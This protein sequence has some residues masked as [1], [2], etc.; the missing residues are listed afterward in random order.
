MHR[1]LALA[2]LFPVVALAGQATVLGAQAERMG[3]HWRFAV[4]V[5]HADTGWDHY[6]DAW[7]VQAPDGTRLAIRELMHPHV[8]EQPFTRTLS[9]VHVPAHVT[10]VLIRAH[11]TVEGW[12]EPFELE[13]PR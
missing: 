3:A 2:L 5:A 4:T 10:R 11:D 8:D 9:A 13:L 1:L 7:E 6:V 12:G